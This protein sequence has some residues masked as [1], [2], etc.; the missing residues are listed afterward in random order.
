[1][2]T[3]GWEIYQAGTWRISNQILALSFSGLSP[4]PGTHPARSKPLETRL[5]L[6]YASLRSNKLGIAIV[7]VEM[8]NVRIFRHL[9]FSFFFSSLA[10]DASPAAM[11][12]WNTIRT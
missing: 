10:S 1:M 12:L 2:A 8:V 9:G 11:Q 3:V 4:S 6:Q 5:F 7:G